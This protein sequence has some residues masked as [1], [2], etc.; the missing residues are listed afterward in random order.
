M[1]LAAALRFAFLFLAV[2]LLPLDT[3]TAQNAVA[4]TGH[5]HLGRGRRDGRRSGQRQEGHH[6]HHGRERRAGPLQLPGQQA[7]AGP[8]RAEHPRDRLRPRQLE[9]GRGRAADHHPQSD[10]QEDRGPRRA[11]VERRV[12]AQHPRHRPAE[13]L[14]AGLRRLPH[15]G[16]LH[17]LVARLQDADGN[18]AAAHAGLREPEHPAEPA[19]AARRAA[20]GGARRSARPGLPQRRRFSRHHQSQRRQV[21]V[22][23]RPEDAAASQGPRHAGDLHRV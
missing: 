6:H 3:A 17:A 11:D 9:D 10:A 13:G 16:A 21:A 2:S 5:G 19:N 18:H 14:V 12:D 7:V 1:R 20:D 23:V 22:G 4:L 15:A 8:V